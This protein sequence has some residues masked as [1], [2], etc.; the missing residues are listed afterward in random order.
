MIRHRRICSAHILLSTFVLLSAA[1]NAQ[2]KP[3]LPNDLGQLIERKTELLARYSKL[4]E[5]GSADEA[6]GVLR[7]IINIHRKSVQVAISNQEAAD[8]IEKLRNVYV[9]D[10][11]FMSD[12]LFQ[13]GEY[14][15]SAALRK[16][17]E[18]FLTPILGEQHRSTVIMHWK[19][20]TAD[21]LAKASRAKQTAY[22]EAL[23][24]EPQATQALADGNLKEATQLYLQLIDAQVAVL[25]EAHPKVAADLNEY[26]RALW[27]QKNYPA[28]EA[29]YHRSLKVREASTGRDLQYATTTFNLGRVY[30]DTNRYEKAEE[31]YLQTAAIE[32]PALGS[33]NPSFLQTLNQ[34]AILYDLMGESEKK[35]A[36]QQRVSAADPLAT[37]LAHMPKG[38]YAAAAVEPVQLPQ[39]AGL[40]MLPFEVMEAAGR[41]QLGVSPLDIE[42]L[43]A[44]ATLPI[45]D[46]PINYGFLF[47]LKD[48]VTATFPWQVEGASEV[49]TFG[50]GLQYLKSSTGNSQLCAV[51]YEDGVVL[52]GTEECV[53]Q[54]LSQPDTGPVGAMLLADR[55]AGQLN[56]AV[57]M[58]LI[59][60]FVQAG[61]QEMP[62]L[63]PELE[64]LRSLPG[65]I[66]SMH[67]RVDLSRGLMLSL[68]LD[69]TD[70][71][72]AEQTVQTL[73]NALAY[74]Q[75]AAAAQIAEELA[76]EQPVDVATR[77]YVQRVASTFLQQLAPVQAENTVT[78]S[79]SLNDSTIVAPIAVALLLPAV[80]GARDAA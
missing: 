6:I 40:Q 63:P 30:Q 22:V 70:V 72:A 51:E 4:Q 8:L 64:P 50:D 68:T 14:A 47:R 45:S 57:D 5:A 52:V 16:E 21:R 17:L 25:G 71:A 37:V 77:K 33:R 1:G 11:E 27:L 60:G 24:I 10:T 43:V 78:L 80:Q 73:T 7:E 59:R 32:E 65:E 26:G 15:E 41:E 66:D 74:G 56:G 53:R 28:A 69:A 34:L 29:V 75:Q 31:M 2:E 18:E 19:A 35:A 23:A 76:G 62:A 44:L 61:L 79:T 36:V 46:P 54:S 13:R 67:L 20:V 42:A 55:E 3:E 49:V 12:Q 38:T 58:K 39:V 9:N 48:G